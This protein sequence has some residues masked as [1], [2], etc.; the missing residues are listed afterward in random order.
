MDPLMTA[1]DAARTLG[2]AQVT[3]RNLRAAGEGPRY[4]RLGAQRGVRY[5]P[6]DLE[7]WVASRE[8]SQ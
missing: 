6:A 5:R 8:A 2:V 3:L 4:V 7:A 1:R